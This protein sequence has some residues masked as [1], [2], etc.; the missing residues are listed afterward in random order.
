M[1]LAAL[2]VADGAVGVKL[3]AVGLKSRKR[4][5]HHAASRSP[6]SSEK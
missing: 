1:I 4:W 6:N 3:A 2:R 5:T